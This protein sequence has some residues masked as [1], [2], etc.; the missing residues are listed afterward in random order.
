[1]MVKTLLYAPLIDG[2]QRSNKQNAFCDSMMMARLD[3]S[4]MP[5]PVRHKKCLFQ[6]EKELTTFNFICQKLL[7]AVF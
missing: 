1:M 6:R 2:G 3:P 7:G 4:Q 5:T